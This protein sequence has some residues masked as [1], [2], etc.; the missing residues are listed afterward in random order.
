MEFGDVS[1]DY[2]LEI[3]SSLPKVHPPAHRTSGP[4][5]QPPHSTPPVDIVRRILPTLRIPLILLSGRT[6]RSHSRVDEICNSI[7]VVAWSLAFY[8][9][10]TVPHNF[11]IVLANT[12][13]EQYPMSICEHVFKTPGM[14]LRTGLTSIPRLTT[15]GRSDM[16]GQLESLTKIPR[17]DAVEKRIQVAHPHGNGRHH[18][19]TN[20]YTRRAARP[21]GSRRGASVSRSAFD[22]KVHSA[23]KH[24]RRS[25]R[26][27][28]LDLQ[29]YTL[30]N[31]ATDSFHPMSGARP[32]APKM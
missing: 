12:R 23:S 21:S 16:R 9:Q 13:S 14:L 18:S 17:A 24:R 20:L 4:C 2:Q 28:A 31:L 1:P 29:Q 10:T 26:R 7:T 8:H 6:R 5:I 3:I 19:Q 32:T 25:V 30:A 27:R 15:S 11:T 22:L